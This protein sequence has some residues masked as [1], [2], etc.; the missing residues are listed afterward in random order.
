MITKTGLESFGE[1]TPRQMEVLVE[2]GRMVLEGTTPT[3]FKGLAARLWVTSDH[4]T[5]LQRKGYLARG[6]GVT[7][8]RRAW[9]T[10]GQAYAPREEPS[11]SK[12]PTSV[13]GVLLLAAWKALKHLITG[14]RPRTKDHSLLRALN[15]HFGEHLPQGPLRTGR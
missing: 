14:G 4:L 13:E 15:R 7:L 2:V 12:A 10:L 9:S 6:P 3:T 1:L 8:T 5:A 11:G